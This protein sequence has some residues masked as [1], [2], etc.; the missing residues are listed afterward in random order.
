MRNQPP[1]LLHFKISHFNEKVRWALD[2]KSWP[3][4][5]KALVPGLHVPRARWISGQNQLPVLCMPGRALPGSNHILEF[6]EK[7]RPDPPLF[8]R[9]AAGYRRALGL[10]QYFDEEVA[11]ELRRLFWACYVSHPAMAARMACDGESPMLQALWRAMF[12]ALLPVFSGNL[13]LDRAT[14]QSAR[15]R[16]PKH[17]DYLE[18]EIGSGGY[19]VGDHFT[20]ADLCAAAVM[21]AVIRPPQF[22]YPLPEPWPTELIE[23]RASVAHRPGFKWVMDI[24]ARHRG[25]S[26]EVLA[27]PVSNQD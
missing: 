7:Q 24:Y 9:D 17:F 25:R 6:I 2:F 8:P 26:S 22:P 18:S 4:R 21:T 10:Q 19:L 16:M 1:L 23:L 3:H 27:P 14:L 5:R 13:G 12:P 20:V 15:Q 11:P